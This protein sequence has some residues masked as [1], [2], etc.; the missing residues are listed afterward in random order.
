MI[1]VMRLRVRCQIVKDHVILFTEDKGL[2]QQIT[3]HV[4]WRARHIP[5]E[6]HAINTLEEA[7]NILQT[8][9]LSVIIIDESAVIHSISYLRDFFS[10]YSH[11]LK[12][13]VLTENLTYEHVRS[14]FLEGAYDVLANPLREDQMNE[15]LWKYVHLKMQRKPLEEKAL[16]ILYA[17]I[18]NHEIPDEFLR[19]Y[20]DMVYDVQ[21]KSTGLHQAVFNLLVPIV[22]DLPIAPV[23]IRGNFLAKLGALWVCKQSEDNLQSDPFDFFKQ[24][25]DFS[26]RLYSDIYYPHI[27]NQIVRKAIY[28][29]LAPSKEIKTVAYIA[30]KL[31]INQSHLSV[32]FRKHTELA[33]SFYIQRVH[34]YG[35][36][37]LLL[38]VTLSISDIIDILGYRDEKHF[39]KVFKS[40]FGK[41]INE[42][43]QQM[44]Y[45]RYQK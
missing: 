25:I 11:N 35:A 36:L 23:Y 31:F 20:F 40:Y 9:T 28:E 21:L 22:E 5:L 17:V 42:Y 27:S 34:L 19:S 43:V 30:N 18:N 13:I 8:F 45:L 12:I 4:K 26:K 1:K 3:Q 6:C 24:V 16:F 7:I 15:V 39:Q 44:S 41:T 38:N 2:V 14:L 29:V 37:L 33:L 32:T 10:H